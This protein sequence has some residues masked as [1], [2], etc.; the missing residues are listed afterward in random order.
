MSVVGGDDNQGIA[1][2]FGKFQ[3]LLY[4]FVQIDGLANLTARIRRVIL[5]ID[6]STFHL[7]EEPLLIAA[8]QIDGFFGHLR[9]RRHRCIAFRVRR[10]GH[11]RL[12]DIAVIRRLWAFPTHRHIAFREETEQRFVLI[13]LA[14]GGQRAGVGDDLVAAGYRLIVQRFALPFTGRRAFREGF[15][16]A[17]Q[18][19]VGTGV[20]QLFGNRT[21]TALF[22]RVAG[23]FFAGHARAVAFTR[24][25][26]R[27]QRSGSGVLQF[28]RGDVTGG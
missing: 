27:H 2:F 13:G 28:R 15:R 5:F 9:Q 1:L 10:T 14:N 25:H 22:Q 24:R 17:A 26:M 12:I 21:F 7:Q 4:R 23:A 3:R 8:Q 6:R 11:R 18:C 20:Q 19:Y 16:A